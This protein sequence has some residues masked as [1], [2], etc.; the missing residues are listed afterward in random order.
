LKKKKGGGGGNRETLE[1]DCCGCVW[2]GSLNIGVGG[3]KHYR[4]LGGWPYKT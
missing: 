3:G 4:N 1:G 2:E